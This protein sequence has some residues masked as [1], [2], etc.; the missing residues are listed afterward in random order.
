MNK[1]VIKINGEESKAVMEVKYLV[2]SNFSYDSDSLTQYMY[3]RT[4]QTRKFEAHG[5]ERA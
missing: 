5:V 1:H 4:I 2:S 3:I